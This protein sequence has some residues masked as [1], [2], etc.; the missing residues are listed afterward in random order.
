M[1]LLY[2][3]PVQA[4]KNNSNLITVVFGKEN[5]FNVLFMSPKPAF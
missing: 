2:G 1:F 3:K 5:I 4:K